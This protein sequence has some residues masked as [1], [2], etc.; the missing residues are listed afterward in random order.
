ME[1]GEY[2]IRKGDVSHAKFIRNKNIKSS[3]THIMDQI[4]FWKV[5]NL[6]AVADM[7]DHLVLCE[8]LVGVFVEVTCG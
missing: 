4:Q 8:D 7:K 3:I 1:G 5:K 2:V 6:K